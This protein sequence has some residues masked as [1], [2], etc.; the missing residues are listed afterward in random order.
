M[1]KLQEMAEGDVIGRVTVS[2]TLSAR[3]REEIAD[4]IVRG[5]L[6]PGVA[7]EEAELAK[8]FEVSRTHVR[9]AIRLLVATGLVE[10][11][12][13]RTAVVARA[14]ETQLV[15]MFEALREL[16]SLCAGFAAERMTPSGHVE[17]RR[18]HAT[19]LRVVRAGNPQQYHE[20]N[21]L[22]HLAIYAGC[23][24]AYL[25][26]LTI[27]TRARIAPFSR[28]QFR[29][30]GRLAR[31]HAEHDAIVKAII[32]GHADRAAAAMK[33]HIGSVH[34]AYATYRGV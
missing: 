20:Q 19:L 28:A 1:P 22:F 31:S 7:L 5:A 6:A 15:G 26:R 23:H 21:E 16:E 3:L 27:E 2:K 10:A 4:D 12:P 30:L 18:I 25:E 24:N 14:T 9:E 11:R 33:T 29:T 34:D 8:R 17:L 32:D 13:H